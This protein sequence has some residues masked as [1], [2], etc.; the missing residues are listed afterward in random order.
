MSVVCT[1]PPEA[2]DLAEHPLPRVI[3]ELWRRRFTGTLHLAHDRVELR[4]AWREG[5][6]VTSESS[7]SDDTLGR[8]LMETGRIGP[9]QLDMLPYE[10]DRPRAIDFD[11]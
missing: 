4:F 7:R 2:G 5:A 3:L 6:L 8:Q 1:A 9:A 11:P 10:R